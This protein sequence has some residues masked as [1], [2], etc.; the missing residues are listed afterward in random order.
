MSPCA[1][2]SP[3]LHELHAREALLHAA[4][5]VPET[6]AVMKILTFT[7][8]AGGTVSVQVC[9][10]DG[11]RIAFVVTEGMMRDLRAPYEFLSDQARRHHDAWH[12][13]HIG[14]GIA[15]ALTH[16][17]LVCPDHRSKDP[18]VTWHGR[19]Q[20]VAATMGFQGKQGSLALPD[21]HPL[22]DGSATIA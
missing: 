22:L 10:A 2:T 4:N 5:A 8:P 13:T 7:D 20:K 15:E 17:L 19:I 6:P 21:D 1:G 16:Y 14:A 3:T 18:G 9:F 11:V 12:Q